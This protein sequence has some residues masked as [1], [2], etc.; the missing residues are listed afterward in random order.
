MLCP[1]W[2]GAIIL[3]GALTGLWISDPSVR[4]IV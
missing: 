3:Q 4:S 1:L 2:D